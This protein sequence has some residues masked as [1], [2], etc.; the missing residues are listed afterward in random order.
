MELKN[1]EAIII[2]KITTPV[3]TLTILAL[4][5]I[6]RSNKIFITKINLLKRE[7][8]NL[9]IISREYTILFSLIVLIVSTV[10]SNYRSFYIEFY[11]KKKYSILITAFLI[12]ILILS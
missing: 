11:N 3:A 6:S 2:T 8:I 7:E 9:T 1:K 5:N 4:L 10:I 12:S